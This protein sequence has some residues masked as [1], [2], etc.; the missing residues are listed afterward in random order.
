MFSLPSMHQHSSVM[1]GPTK[2]GPIETGQYHGHGTSARRQ[3]ITAMIDH[4]ASRPGGTGSGAGVVGGGCAQVG[5]AF[6]VSAVGGSTRKSRVHSF[7]TSLRSAGSGTVS[8]WSYVHTR[9][10]REKAANSHS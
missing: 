7:V 2:A 10:D 6:S 3:G 4:T 8:R 1:H 9:A 5:T